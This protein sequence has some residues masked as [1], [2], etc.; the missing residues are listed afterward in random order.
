MSD[1]KRLRLLPS[2]VLFGSS[3]PVLAMFS[4]CR[5]FCWVHIRR[6]IL[7]TLLDQGKRGGD[8]RRGGRGHTRE[9]C[10]ESPTDAS[11]VTDRLRSPRAV[12]VVAAA[13]TCGDVT[14]EV[15]VVHGSLYCRVRAGFGLKV[16]EEEEE[17]EEGGG[18]S[19]RARPG[20]ATSVRCW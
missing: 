8:Y 2:R 15:A 17:E 14:H 1:L 19:A 16:N 7:I 5:F 20:P 6:K 13:R 3:S 10:A 11:T 4:R 9:G 18:G 12:A